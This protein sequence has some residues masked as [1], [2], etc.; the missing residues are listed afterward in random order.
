M[1]SV[2]LFAWF[3]FTDI[4]RGYKTLINKHTVI[5]YKSFDLTLTITVAVIFGLGSIMLFIFNPGLGA[6]FSGLTFIVFFVHYA[7]EFVIFDFSSNSVSGLFGKGKTEINQLSM[8]VL[9]GKDQI[10]FKS[11]NHTSPVTLIKNKVG[12]STWNTLLSN[13]DL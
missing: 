10:R 2:G 6:V 5:I 11:P 13:F 9:P 3:M 12:D 8:E 1:A 7:F 4:Y